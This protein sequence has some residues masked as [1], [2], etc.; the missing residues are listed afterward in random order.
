MLNVLFIAED[1]SEQLHKMYHY[2]EQEL[3]KTVN[4]TMW[5]NPGHM[6]YILNQLPVR[7][8]FILLLNDIGRQMKPLM[9]GLSRTGI[10]TGL[11][12]NDV[13]R[14]V[15]LRR[16]YVTKH[17]IAHLFTV[18]RDKFIELYPEFINK[19]EW[20][21]HFVQTEIYR[22]YGMKK[23]IDLLMMGAVND[24]YP[25]RQKIVEAYE[26]NPNFTYHRHPGYQNVSRIDKDQ[27]FIGQKYAIELNRAKIVF[28]CPSVFYYPV[29]KYFE[30]LACKSLLLAPTFPEL[31][32]LGFIPG[33]HFVPI[34]EDDFME[35]AAYY[36]ANETERKQIAEQGYQFIRQTHSAKIRTEQL[37]KRIESIL[38]Q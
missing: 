5:R 13:H 10:P 6:D 16:N 17:N 4:L 14:L 1:T 30:I 32:D 31:E 26:G 34:D 29:I 36:V 19:M 37:V 25:L 22:D 35:K 28:T 21:P 11:F 15:K 8:D 27:H 7:P 38:Q 9:N 33:Y 20:F 12:V 3:A 24:I 2:L 18:T 23:D